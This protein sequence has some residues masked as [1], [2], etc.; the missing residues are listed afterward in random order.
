M[1]NIFSFGIQA[2][3]PGKEEEEKE[4]ELGGIIPLRAV[5]GNLR[6][7]CVEIALLFATYA[8]FYFTCYIA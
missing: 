8:L 6:E 2:S 3:V 1:G 5:H 4:Q 7:K